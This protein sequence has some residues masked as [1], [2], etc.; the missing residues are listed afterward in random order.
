MERLLR[1]AGVGDD[2]AQIEE[3]RGVADG[4]RDERPQCV[5]ECAERGLR[6]GDER[7]LDVVAVPPLVHAA[8]GVGLV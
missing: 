2:G 4:G 6:L 8:E 5:C 7:Q 1:R 3:L